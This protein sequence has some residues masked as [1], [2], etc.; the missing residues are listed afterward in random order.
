MSNKNIEERKAALQSHIMLFLVFWLGVAQVFSS[1]KLAAIIDWSLLLLGIVVVLL[2]HVKARPL[3][4]HIIRLTKEGIEN[5]IIH[6]S[7]LYWLLMAF[8]CCF[9]F[10]YI[11]ALYLYSVNNVVRDPDFDGGAILMIVMLGALLMLLVRNSVFRDI[12]ASM[13]EQ[14]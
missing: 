14:A 2:L 9:T 8:T 12:L 4:K 3:P 1:Y 5:E 13:K 6:T 10:Y 11:F 7:K